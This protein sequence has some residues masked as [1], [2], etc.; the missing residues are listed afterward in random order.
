MTSDSAGR[1]A[2]DAASRPASAFAFRDFGELLPEQGHIQDNAHPCIGGNDSKHIASS[3]S[4]ERDTFD[5]YILR[6]VSIDVSYQRSAESQDNARP[7]AD[8]LRRDEARGDAVAGVAVPAD[9]LTH[10]DCHYSP[11]QMVAQESQW[12]PEP[13]L[14]GT[15]LDLARLAEPLEVPAQSQYSL[16]LRSPLSSTFAVAALVQVSHP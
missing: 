7:R 13:V 8:T 9:D 11:T 15:V 6:C 10:S 1:L 2:D 14:A 4:E 5:L 3:R 12:P 16:L